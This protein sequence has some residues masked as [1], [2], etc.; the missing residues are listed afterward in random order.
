MNWNDQSPLPHR[1]ESACTPAECI[2]ATRPARCALSCY[3]SRSAPCGRLLAFILDNLSR[4]PN[5]DWLYRGSVRLAADATGIQHRQARR[6]VARYIRNGLFQP[7]GAYQPG[8]SR[9]YRVFLNV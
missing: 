8:K 4:A 3:G 5:G 2:G 1:E 6:C 9:V 7:L